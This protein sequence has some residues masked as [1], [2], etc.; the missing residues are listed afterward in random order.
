M[1]PVINAARHPASF[2]TQTTT[3]SNTLA[4]ETVLNRVRSLKREELVWGAVVF[5]EVLGFFTLGEIIGRR[6]IVGY[7]GDVHHHETATPHD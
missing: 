6:K 2:F 5:A 4:P 3:K 1:Q 7:R